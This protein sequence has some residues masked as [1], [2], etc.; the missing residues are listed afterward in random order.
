MKPEETTEHRRFEERWQ[1]KDDPEMRKI[2]LRDEDYR[3]SP[4]RR[5]RLFYI[6]FILSG[7]LLFAAIAVVLRLYLR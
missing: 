7:M 4:R 6:S 2:H 1:G 5:N 3:V